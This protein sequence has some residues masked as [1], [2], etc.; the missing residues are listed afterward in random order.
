[1]NTRIGAIQKW[2]RSGGELNGRACADET[3][4]VGETEEKL[5]VRTSLEIACTHMTKQSSFQDQMLV[6]FDSTTMLTHRECSLQGSL[7]LCQPPLPLRKQTE[8][9]SA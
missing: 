3:T 6:A 4:H 5:R 8:I 1:M 9:P 2:Q 7:Q